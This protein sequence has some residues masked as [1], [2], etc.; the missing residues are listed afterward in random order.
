ME[1]HLQ[2]EGPQG[3]TE[4]TLANW[5]PHLQMEGPQGATE[6]MLAN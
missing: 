2:M 3:A 5:E 6:G 1:P 4:G